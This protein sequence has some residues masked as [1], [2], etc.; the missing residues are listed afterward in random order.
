MCICSSLCTH[1]P[2][3]HASCSTSKIGWLEQKPRGWQDFCFLKFV[4]LEQF[5][6]S[7]RPHT[8]SGQRP[9]LAM[10]R[11][12]LRA[13][14]QDHLP[15]VRLDGGTT[16]KTTLLEHDIALP[17]TRV[18]LPLA[19]PDLLCS[20]NNIL[21]LATVRFRPAR[22]RVLV[23]GSARIGS[24][25]GH[26]GHD[27]PSYDRDRWPSCAQKA[28]PCLHASHWALACSLLQDTR[29]APVVAYP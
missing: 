29:K 13:P 18:A 28:E 12:W 20:K 3:S 23:A 24:G 5:D 8:R 7:N 17:I 19:A 25:D 11:S 15:F 26:G 27:L 1:L 14:V 22:R 6:L 16:H 2:A 21:Q 4:S 10:A 9:R